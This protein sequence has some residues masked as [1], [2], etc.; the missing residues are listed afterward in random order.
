[1]A[2]ECAA[3]FGD[4]ETSANGFGVNW[5]CVAW[6]G[7]RSC[8]VPGIP[9]FAEDLA[10]G[11]CLEQDGRRRWRVEATVDGAALGL[12]AATLVDATGRAAVPSR[13]FGARRIIL[14]RLVGVVA[15]L[16][17]EAAA[18]GA[19][20]RAL[21]SFHRANDGRFV[22]GA[23][24]ARG[25]RLPARRGKRPPTRGAPGVSGEILPEARAVRMGQAVGRVGII[26][27]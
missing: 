11:H 16:A 2:A 8:R 22:S 17:A 25:T 15:W 19:D 26:F 6:R 9:R 27:W 10:S 21:I 12:V 20:R 3:A 23:A 7:H 5:D 14:D 4:A 18:I 1:L 24:C 13:R